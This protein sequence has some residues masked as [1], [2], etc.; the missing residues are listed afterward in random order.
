MAPK[1]PAATGKPAGKKGSVVAKAP[2]PRTNVAPAV[3]TPA[4]PETDAAPPKAAPA[5]AA[6]AKA[7]P[8]KA[9]PGTAPTARAT[10][11]T[12]A[13]APLPGAL[14]AE[15]AAMLPHHVVQ[16]LLRIATNIEALLASYHETHAVCQAA[17]QLAEI[18]GREP[19]LKW[20]QVVPP[21]CVGCSPK[22]RGGFG[23]QVHKCV[24]NG[25][26]HCR[27]GYS[28]PKACRGAVAKTPP[29]LQSHLQAAVAFQ[30]S[31]SAT[32]PE[33][34]S[35]LGLMLISLGNGHCNG[36]LR[37][38]KGRAK[39][40]DQDLAPLG[41]LDPD[42]LSAQRPGLAKAL[43]G[44]DWTVYHSSIFAA[45]PILED[46]V[47]QAENT[48]GRQEIG[49]LEGMLTMA[50]ARDVYVSAG[51]EPAWDKV[52]ATGVQ[53]EPMWKP[54]SA[55]L[56]EVVKTT[57]TDCIL[58]VAACF[59]AMGGGQSQTISHMGQAFLSKVAT[60]K[61][62]GLVVC[63]RVRMATILANMLSPIECVDSG[64]Y[65]LLSPN[66]L[67]ILQTKKCVSHTRT[68]ENIMEKARALC[69]EHKVEEGARQ[70]ATAQLDTR[71]ILHTVKKD[72]K[73]GE[74][75]VSIFAICE[76]F[77]ADIKVECMPEE[78]ESLRP[79]AGDDDAEP[80]E[81]AAAPVAATVLQATCLEE[82][83]DPVHA[84]KRL[85]F[86]VGDYIRPKV[87]PDSDDE[88]EEK[89]VYKIESMDASGVKCTIYSVVGDTDDGQIGKQTIE[90]EAVALDFKKTVLKRQQV[91]DFTEWEPTKN[92]PL[93]MEMLKASCV[94]A[95]DQ[96]YTA[97]EKDH[98]QHIRVLD[99]P[100]G[101]KIIKGAFKKNSLV[102]V[103]ACRNIGVRAVATGGAA[104]GVTVSLGTHTVGDATVQVFANSVFTMTGDL[105]KRF[106]APFW[107]VRRLKAKDMEDETC[108]MSWDDRVVPVFV[109]VGN[110]LH[111]IRVPVM[112][113]S[114]ALKE[115]DV[116]KVADWTEIE[117]SKRQK[118]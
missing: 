36:W 3:Q 6:P 23:L 118:A 86:N 74:I 50:R 113:N 7:A 26:K 68:L 58:E 92:I 104:A 9:A 80:P 30:E 95:L 34:P 76:A 15:E 39:C 69:V 43:A 8:A 105:A 45:W 114:V 93:K 61:T 96:L 103:P 88:D 52:L 102:L 16:A 31:L 22:N 83:K 66:D 44:L 21:E 49:E 53:T 59:K 73:A 13:S 12:A 84:L 87:A 75:F 47:I 94:M 89:V 91:I 18:S 41:V 25:G 115:G 5:K 108:N 97:L 55:C 112:V 11:S 109:G 17:D 101:V 10:T 51:K 81:A 116:L 1:K 79:A 65:S 48:E 19:A 106:V 54:W 99:R 20:S 70:R 67:N 60:F 2:A 117:S 4:A 71:L 110:L 63:G 32:Q 62:L 72:K 78:W 98:A 24:E 85:G 46:I 107:C 35:L 90:L 77:L 37:L 64:R 100:K 57:T 56:L 14:S 28:Y 111:K 82:L 38:V 29:V 33:L 40:P 42:E 27:A